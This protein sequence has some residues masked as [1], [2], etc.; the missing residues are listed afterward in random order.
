LLHVFIIKGL[1]VTLHFANFVSEVDE[2]EIAT[3]EKYPEHTFEVG[4][5]RRRAYLITA[6]NEEGKKAWVET[7]KICCRKASGKSA[8]NF[9]SLHSKLPRIE[10]IHYTIHVL[11]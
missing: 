2:K 1:A 10:C 11:Q 8:L 9:L 7:F 4:H 5:S 3:P 6:E